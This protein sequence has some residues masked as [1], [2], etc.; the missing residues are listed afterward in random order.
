MALNVFLKG[1]SHY[2]AR[3]LTINY[4]NNTI[5]VERP[6]NTDIRH[7][8]V[9]TFTNLT[10]VIYIGDLQLSDKLSKTSNKNLLFFVKDL[11]VMVRLLPKIARTV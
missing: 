3:T 4:I 2:N 6:C 8:P 1:G 9:F 7:V 10:E 5:F 11:L